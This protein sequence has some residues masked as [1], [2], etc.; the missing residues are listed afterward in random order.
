MAVVIVVMVVVVVAVIVVMAEGVVVMAS[1]IIS[2]GGGVSNCNDGRDDYGYGDDGFDN[3]CSDGSD[4]GCDRGCGGTKCCCSCENRGYNRHK[5][6][7]KILSKSPGK[8]AHNRKED[9]TQFHIQ[10]KI[11]IEL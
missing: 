1:V 9:S 8:T 2:C 6:S 10:L 4:G 11:T 7:K 5:I 3:S